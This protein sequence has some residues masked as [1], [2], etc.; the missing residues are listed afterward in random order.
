MSSNFHN[1][2]KVSLQIQKV[3]FIRS[4]TSTKK[5]FNLKK[6]NNSLLRSQLIL[7]NRLKRQISKINV[8]QANTFPVNVIKKVMLRRR[9]LWQ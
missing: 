2:N 3:P 5:N 8:K 9:Q 1:V 6:Q 4:R 7:K